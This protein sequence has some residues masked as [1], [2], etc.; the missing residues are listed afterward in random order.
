[1]RKFNDHDPFV[2]KTVQGGGTS[3]GEDIPQ[4]VLSGHFIQSHPPISFAGLKNRPVACDCLT[5]QFHA[6]VSVSIRRT[7]IS[8]L[9]LALVRCFSVL[10]GVLWLMGILRLWFLLTAYGYDLHSS[11][12]GFIF[13][14]FPADVLF[15]WELKDENFMFVPLQTKFALIHKIRAWFNRIKS[16]LC[17]L[18][19][20]SW[21]EC[22]RRQV[23][24][25]VHYA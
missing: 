4:G 11:D 21:S 15:G 6:A 1:M 3:A 13:H 24:N 5:N 7:R 14:C 12:R 9:C 8:F 23:D 2:N 19:V 20:S 17:I 10:S 18:A 25:V 16:M 22:C